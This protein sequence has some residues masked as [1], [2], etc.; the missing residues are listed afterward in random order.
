MKDRKPIFSFISNSYSKFYS[1]ST[2]EPHII[3]SKKK[4]E[5]KVYQNIFWG[6]ALLFF[7]LAMLVYSKSTNWT[8]TVY[9]QDAS[10]VKTFVYSFSFLLSVTAFAAGYFL[11]PEREAIKGVVAQFEKCL[12][13][14]YKKQ[15][16]EINWFY[17]WYGNGYAQKTTFKEGYQQVLLK[18]KEYKDTTLHL[19]EKIDRSPYD[20][21][22]KEKLI[23]QAI[24]DLQEELNSIVQYYKQKH[25]LLIESNTFE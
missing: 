9:F 13:I 4:A 25:Y 18:V 8:S 3:Y 1:S 20:L 24:F 12:K 6:L 23:N 2:T 10:F 19:L 14:L 22:V 15:L 17:S 21:S 11:K 16:A 7:V 5:H